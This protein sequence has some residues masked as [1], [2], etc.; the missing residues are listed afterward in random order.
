[1]FKKYLLPL[2][3]IVLVAGL[4]LDLFAPVKRDFKIFDPVTVG[5]LDAAMWRSYYEKK[6]TQL[7]FQLGSLVHHQFQA[8]RFRSYMI[9]YYSAK[10]AFIFKNGH[11]R[12][13]Y[14][15]ALPYLVAYY[16]QLESISKSHFNFRLMAK[17][18]LEW[19][20]IRRESDIHTPEDWKILLGQ[21]AE[22]MYSIPANRFGTY[23]E[24]RVQAMLLRDGKGQT[25]DEDDWKQ[26]E[27][28]CI[29]AWTAFHD[30]VKVP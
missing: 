23:A 16:Q 11:D 26:I 21:Q 10:A 20:I 27:K 19:W 6:P 28:R 29:D 8:P 30:A 17:T 24:Q 4:A 5:K 2:S 12:A 9:A 1:M 13:D 14:E 25:M 15:K 7:F 18:E 22:I 3:S